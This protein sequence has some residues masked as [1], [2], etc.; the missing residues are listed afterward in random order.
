MSTTPPRVPNTV[1]TMLDMQQARRYY[2]AGHWRDETFY[3]AIRVHAGRAPDRV[4]VRESQRQVSYAELVD[5]ADRLAAHLSESGL[6]RGQRVAVWLPSRIE[7]VV[8]LLACSR[9]G[10]VCCPSL[11]RDHTVS[12]VVD[13]LRRM[14]AAAL[15]GTPGYGADAHRVDVFGEVADLPSLRTVIQLGRADADERVFAELTERDSEPRETDPDTVVY[16]AFTSG[17]TGEPKGVMHSDNTVLAPARAMAADWSIG[18]DT[19]VYTLSPISHNL[20]LGAMVMALAHGG[21]LVVHDLPRSA[22]L[23]DRLDETGTAFVVGVP[24]H[25]IDLLAE[26]EQRQLEKLGSVRGFRVS[27]APVAPVLATR[28]L[29][30]GIVPQSGYGMT[31]AGSHN[32]TR[33]DDAK[34]LI[35]NS[36]GRACAGYETAI[37]ARDDADRLLPPGEEGQIGAR[38]ACLMLGYFE[39]QEATESSFNRDGWFLTGDT[40][41]MDE[42]GY[43]RVTGRRKDVIIRGGHNI[44]PARIENLALRHGAV[45]KAAAIP[46]PDARLGEK[47]CLVVVVRNGEQVTAAELL[48]HLD[49][50]GLSRYDMPEYLVEVAELP[51]LPSGKVMK[52]RL[53]EW[54]DDGTIA[55]EP[56]RFVS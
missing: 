11:H 5:A 26:M 43:I 48:S 51:T 13:L 1:L 25:A 17:S 14:R 37:F 33:P 29:E 53:V 7:T 9:N 55:P 28:L 46:V 2:R 4:A 56:V 20:G 44:Q 10:Y 22:S 30:H 34:E 3:D 24:T 38:G 39:D 41:W 23:A 19:V 31:E 27:G 49:A 36:S 45:D 50:A 8:T 47:V 54:V 21:E 6:R 42:A 40:G 12:E 32:Y 16:L 18:A 15:I 52:R 35:V